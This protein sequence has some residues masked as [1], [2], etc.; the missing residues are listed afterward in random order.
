M[1]IND[2]V[3]HVVFFCDPQLGTT[4]DLG[5]VYTTKN[6]CSQAILWVRY[7]YY[8]SAFTC[9]ERLLLWLLPCTTSF[10]SNRTVQPEKVI[11]QVW[12]SQ[13]QLSTNMVHSYYQQTVIFPYNSISWC[14][15]LNSV[16]TKLLQKNWAG[17]SSKISPYEVF[18]LTS[19]LE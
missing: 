5:D 1:W 8:A 16:L 2:K 4:G 6:S 9:R 19:S 15:S 13:K 14:N 10:S 3:I 12:E 18:I 7:W 11:G 17:R